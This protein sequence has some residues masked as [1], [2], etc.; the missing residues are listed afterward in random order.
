MNKQQLKIY[1][2]PQDQNKIDKRSKGEIKAVVSPIKKEPKYTNSV[3]S[4]LAT[5]IITFWPF[6]VQKMVR[7]MQ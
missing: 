6:P 4:I 2:F 7:I 1:Y 3:K 5:Q